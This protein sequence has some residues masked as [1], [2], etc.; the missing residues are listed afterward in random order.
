MLFYFPSAS[1]FYIYC[2]HK[3]GTRYSGYPSPRE[4]ATRSGIKESSTRSAC[5]ARGE[6]VIRD[7]L[8]VL[9]VSF[10]V[11]AIMEYSRPTRFPTSPPPPPTLLSADIR[12]TTSPHAESRESREFAIHVIR[13]P[14][15][16]PRLY[17]CASRLYSAPRRMRRLPFHETLYKRLGTYE[18]SFLSRGTIFSISFVGLNARS[19]Q[20]VRCTSRAPERNRDTHRHSGRSAVVFFSSDEDVFRF[21]CSKAVKP[22]GMRAR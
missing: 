13:Q 16:A 21:Y 7:Q 12:V 2:F 17:L 20:D 22:N 1:L 11:L 8:S 18:R 9:L 10:S 3:K 15:L 19:P 14:E 6:F 5:R 4:S